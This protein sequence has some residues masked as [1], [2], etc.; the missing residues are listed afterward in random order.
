MF[1][2]TFRWARLLIFVFFWQMCTCTM[3][4]QLYCSVVINTVS[5]RIKLKYMILIISKGIFSFVLILKF[6]WHHHFVMIIFFVI[7]VCFSLLF[8]LYNDK[9][10][11]N[12]HWILNIYYYFWLR[13]LEVDFYK[14][15]NKWNLL[16]IVKHKK[17]QK[18]IL[19]IRRKKFLTKS[20]EEKNST[21]RNFE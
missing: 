10:N 16:I 18:F 2:F 19:D 5:V 21:K 3:D 7:F 12:F 4:K 13:I 17:F 14:M 15:K 20:F 11:L 6:C 8:L 1:L 9:L